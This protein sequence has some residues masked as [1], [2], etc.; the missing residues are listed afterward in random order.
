MIHELKAID[1]SKTF[2]DKFVLD[3]LNLE[4]E[5]S[6]KA[7][8]LGANG[9]GKSTLL[10][11]LAGQLPQDRGDIIINK[12]KI[13][14]LQSHLRNSIVYISSRQNGLYPHLNIKENILFFQKA[15]NL[16]SND[17]LARVKRWEMIEA[18]KLALITPFSKCSKGMKQISLIFIQTMHSPEIILLDEPFSGLDENNKEL[19]YKLMEH[20]FKDQTILMASHDKNSSFYKNYTHFYLKDGQIAT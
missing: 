18:F 5:K 16:N 1:I 20:E 4:L 17:I 19:T 13:T 10:K 6:Q 2:S 11:I 15:S 8:L 14:L 9:S 12:K 7:V 3:N